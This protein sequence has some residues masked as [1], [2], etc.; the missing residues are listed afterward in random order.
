MIRYIL[1]ILMVS[2]FFSVNSLHASTAFVNGYWYQ[3]SQFVQ[4]TMYVENG[5]FVSSPPATIG[6]VVDLGGGFVIPPLAEAHNHNLQNPWL[7]ERFS[8]QYLKAGIFYSLMMCG[9]KDAADASRNILAATV[10]DV[11]FASAC[12]S[13]SDGHPLRMALAVE[14][15]QPAP[16]LAQIYDKSYIVMDSVDDISL[17]WPLVEAA[18]ADIVKLI[19]VNSEDPKR[20]GDAR[21]FGINGLKP[22]LVEPLTSF[23]HKKGLRVAA[24]V[25]SAADFAVAVKAGVD[26][27]AHLPGYNWQDDYD[28]STYLLDPDIVSLAAARGIKVIATAGVAQLFKQK[29]ERAEEIRATQKLNLQRLKDAGVSVLLGS[30]RFDKNIL[31]EI[32]YLDELALYSRTELLDMAVTKTVSAIWPAKK[33]G[34]LKPGYQADFLVLEENPLTRLQA[35]E[36]IRLS[37]AAGQ[38]TLQ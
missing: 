26:I 5:F 16:Q 7:A 29:S 3:G 6:K 10:L 28:Q 22:E 35:L 4:Q 2:I 32:Y 11:A 25:D 18:R 27:V 31:S 15:G 37:F 23:L 12:I 36:T 24:H 20:R 17:K 19:L 38:P 33:Y 8:K 13:S 9:N 14:D 21:F 1:S 30:D 34:Q